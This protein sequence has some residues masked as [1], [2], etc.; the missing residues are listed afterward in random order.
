[1][2]SV[3]LHRLTITS[4]AVAKLRK[5]GL[6]RYRLIQD[7]Y[8]NCR[9][10]GPPING[11]PFRFYSLLNPFLY[12][13]TLLQ[14]NE[15]PSRVCRDRGRSVCEFNATQDHVRNKGRLCWL[16]WLYLSG[17][18][19]L[20]IHNRGSQTAE[21]MR[22]SVPGHFQDIK[23]L[24]SGV[25]LSRL[26]IATH[27][28]QLWYLLLDWV[29]A[30]EESMWVVLG[31]WGYRSSGECDT[32]DGRVNINSVKWRVLIDFV[33]LIYLKIDHE[34]LQRRR[35]RREMWSNSCN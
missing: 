20:Q 16:Q 2:L 11:M 33:Y 6:K 31:M 12:G 7:L 8:V 14:D 35:N 18:L 19:S 21:L 3:N 9:I 29:T 24:V 17:T 25:Q 23:V 10:C 30:M 32:V 5:M 22:G 26:F 15:R 13:S 4:A 28:S 27:S 34:C 1:M